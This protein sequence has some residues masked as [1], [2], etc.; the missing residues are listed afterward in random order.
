MFGSEADR[1]HATHHRSNRA[2]LEGRVLLIQLIEI[3][4]ILE[5]QHRAVPGVTHRFAVEDS[6]HFL[7]RWPTTI[8]PASHLIAQR[9][10]PG[11]H[12]V[13]IL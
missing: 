8:D 10:Q 9:F 3:P 12:A 13:F 1:L 5:Q 11:L 6:T 7:Q 2:E 4:L